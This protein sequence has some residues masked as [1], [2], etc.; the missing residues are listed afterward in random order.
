MQCHVGSFDEDDIQDLIRES[1]LMYKLNHRNVLSIIGLCLDAGPSP[2][3]ILPFMENG[4]LRSYVKKN[5]ARLYTNIET[6][7]E[8]VNIIIIIA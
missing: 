2:Y 4:N 5:K 6:D 1:V 3:I 8:E 7:E